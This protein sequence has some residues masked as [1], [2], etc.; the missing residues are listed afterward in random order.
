MHS[1]YDFRVM[2]EMANKFI[3]K[4]FMTIMEEGDELLKL[5]K[6]EFKTI[7]ENNHLNVNRE[8]LVWDVILKWID[9]HPERRKFDVVFLMPAVRFGLMDTRYFIDN[10]SLKFIG[11]TAED[12][13]I[14]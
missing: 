6:E 13:Q 8:E 12:E 10:V 9:Y 4:Y 2:V 14:Y 11:V 3:T 7:I 1:Y 5:E